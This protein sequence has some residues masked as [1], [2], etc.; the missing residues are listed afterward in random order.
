LEAYLKGKRVPIDPFGQQV[1]WPEMHDSERD[2][3]DNSEAQELGQ[4]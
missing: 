4:I 2:L 1:I 3:F